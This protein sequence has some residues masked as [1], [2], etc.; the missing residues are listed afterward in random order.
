MDKRYL[1][2]R[3]VYDCRAKTSSYPVFPNL[4]VNTM[5]II[6]NAFFSIC[7]RSKNNE[8]KVQK[9]P[10]INGFGKTVVYVGVC[11]MVNFKGKKFSIYCKMTFPP[12]FPMVPPIF[13]I[14]NINP[15]QF[16]VNKIFFNNILPDKSYEVKLL[17]SLHWK[18]NFDFENLLK[19]FISTLEGSFPFFS[20]NIPR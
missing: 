8:V 13:S 14:I 4:Q 17:N 1:I 20:T 11:L 12:N 3:L 10:E 6:Q 16:E 19:E 9:Y 7:T 18:Q 5:Q 15:Q 2:E